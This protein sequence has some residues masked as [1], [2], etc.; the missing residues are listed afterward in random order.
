MIESDMHK[1]KSSITC[2]LCDQIFTSPIH[3]TKATNLPGTATHAIDFG[4]GGLSGI[5]L[6]TLRNLDGRGV[7]IIVGGAKG[8]EDAE[9]S[10]LLD[11]KHESC[12]NKKWATSLVQT[13]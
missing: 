4:P 2:S 13:R 11:A 10:N 1:L 5:G 12:W 8:K 7:H 9:L 6:L 3:W